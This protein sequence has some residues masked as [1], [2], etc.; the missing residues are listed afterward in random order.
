MEGRVSSDSGERAV[1]DSYAG[2]AGGF[3]EA[4]CAAVSRLGS[5]FAS[6]AHSVRRRRTRSRLRPRCPASAPSSPICP[7]QAIRSRLLG[8]SAT[9]HTRAQELEILNILNGPEVIPSGLDPRCGR[10]LEITAQTHPTIS[11]ARGPN[12]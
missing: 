5:R 12:R 8:D 2:C 11:I 1:P 4:G 7:D 10:S 9:I 3:R 6:V